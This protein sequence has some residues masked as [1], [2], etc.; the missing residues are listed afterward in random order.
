[1]KLARLLSP[2]AAAGSSFSVLDDSGR[3]VL[4]GRVGRDLGRWNGGFPH[5]YPIDFSGVRGAGTYSIAV[6]GA[7]QARSPAF[8][9]G[10]PSG[11]YAGLAGNE[12]RF[13][14]GQRDGPDVDRS[15]LGRQPTHLADRSA[16]VYRTPRY[17]GDQLVGRLHPAGGSADVLGGWMDAGDT[18]KYAETGSFA[19]ALL[20]YAIRD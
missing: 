11:L 13:L 20:L 7:V 1:V 14:R 19:D 10:D 16:L 18:L 6:S 17:R 15:I 12:V 4:K 3:T 8:R 5:V 9:V 2:V